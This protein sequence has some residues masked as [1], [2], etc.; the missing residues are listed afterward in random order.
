MGLI[1]NFCLRRSL[2]LPERSLWRP[3]GIFIR[4]GLFVSTTYRSN[5]CTR[6][7]GEFG[8]RQSLLFYALSIPNM[9]V[10]TIYKEISYRFQRQR[11][12]CKRV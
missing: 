8:A 5:G 12:V 9:E 3:A 1:K 11:C 2:R 6:K 10:K 4:M 7:R